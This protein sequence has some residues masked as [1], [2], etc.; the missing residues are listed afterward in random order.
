MRVSQSSASRPCDRARELARLPSPPLKKPPK[1]HWLPDEILCLRHYRDHGNTWAG[2][3]TAMDACYQLLVSSN[4]CRSAYMK[5]RDYKIGRDEEGKEL[6]FMPPG[7]EVIELRKKE[8]ETRK[9]SREAKRVEKEKVQEKSEMGIHEWTAEEIQV[10][11]YYKG[12][13]ERSFDE[14]AVVLDSCCQVLVSAGAVEKLWERLVLEKGE[15]EGV[16]VCLLE[17]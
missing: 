1:H 12:T 8:K 11:R 7:S 5:Y 16:E 2:C 17:G 14:V 3:A 9:S 13:C 6:V 15:A 10:V 4:A